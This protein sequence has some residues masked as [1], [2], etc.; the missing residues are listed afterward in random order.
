MPHVTFRGNRSPH[1]TDRVRAGFARSRSVSA[2]EELVHAHTRT[3]MRAIA[4]LHTCVNIS[5]RRRAEA[6]RRATTRADV[7][8]G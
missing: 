3:G 8:V 2:R 5:G 1:R 4:R 7:V 6:R